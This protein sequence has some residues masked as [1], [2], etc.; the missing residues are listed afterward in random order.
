M[1]EAQNTK[2][3]ILLSPQL[4]HDANFA[5][6]GYVDT[7]GWGYAEFLLITGTMAAAIG[8]TAEGT[9]PF[10]EE[11]D[12]SGGSYTAVDDAELA[13]AI[14][15]TGDDKLYQIDV[16]LTKKHKRYMAVNT[17]HG[18]DGDNYLAI[19][20]ILSRPEIGPAS[21]AERGLAEH[22]IA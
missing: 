8:S 10:I 7:A 21:A 12:T 15:N 5:A 13:A 9:A 3:V 16:N 19:I 22:I 1:I 18:G 17:P 2:K 11:C 6:N 14:A 4:A 20:C